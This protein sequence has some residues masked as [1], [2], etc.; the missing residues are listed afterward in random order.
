METELIVC[1]GYDIAGSP[2]AFLNEVEGPPAKSA[3]P[4]SPG[5]LSLQ[6]D[7]NAAKIVAQI[8]PHTCLSYL[9]CGD[10]NRWVTISI[11]AALRYSTK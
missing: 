1:A 5:S 4:P 8:Y 3:L 10:P 9:N 7:E 11:S 2:K 6:F